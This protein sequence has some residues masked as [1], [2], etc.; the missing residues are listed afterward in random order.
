M[1]VWAHTLTRMCSHTPSTECTHARTHSPTH[2][3]V[4][5]HPH[6]RVLTHWCTCSHP[7]HPEVHLSETPSEAEKAKKDPPLEPKEGTNP[8]SILILDFWPPEL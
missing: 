4:H 1:H 8:G 7:F 6:V 2:S 5:T 3:C